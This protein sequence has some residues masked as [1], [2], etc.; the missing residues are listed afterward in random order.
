MG[1]IGLWPMPCLGLFILAENGIYIR[2]RV[3]GRERSQMMRDEVV[4][5]ST[6][7]T[8]VQPLR[9]SMQRKEHSSQSAAGLGKGQLVEM[10]P[11]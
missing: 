3:L 4:R 1:L 7:L 5:L 2:S 9:V 8:S 10:R 11:N 6:A